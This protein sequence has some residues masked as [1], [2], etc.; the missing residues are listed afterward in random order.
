MKWVAKQF[1]ELK[2]NG[3]KWLCDGDIYLILAGAFKRN[4]AG[5]L[6]VGI[7]QPLP[8]NPEILIGAQTKLHGLGTRAW[9][10]SDDS[11]NTEMDVWAM[12]EITP[13]TEA[14]TGHAPVEGIYSTFTVNSGKGWETLD[15]LER[16]S[17]QC[18]RFTRLGSIIDKDGPYETW[19]FE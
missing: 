15:N 18:T 14:L 2:N 17:Y 12:F 1:E 5:G 6:G 11:N 13:T 3:E 8:A 19:T 9:I 16:H 10:W 4:S 7:V